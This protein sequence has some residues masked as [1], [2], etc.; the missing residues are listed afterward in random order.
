MATGRTAYV[1]K[2]GD[3]IRPSEWRELHKDKAY[4][5]YGEYEAG[6]FRVTAEWNGEIPYANDIPRSEWKAFELVVQ[7]KSTHDRDGHELPE[8]V[9]VKDVISCEKFKTREET[10]EAMKDWLLENC[11]FEYEIPELDSK[12]EPEP[13]PTYKDDDDDND[14]G[15]LKP[16]EHGFVESRSTETTRLIEPVPVVAGGEYDSPTTAD[17]ET[18]SW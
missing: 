4:V 9:W 2:W 15:E 10:L 12:P 18:G 3:I 13:E 5:V 16:G 14:D 11:E 6:R 17:E 1:D 8:P 7:I